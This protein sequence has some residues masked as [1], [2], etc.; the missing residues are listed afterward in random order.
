MKV[1]PTPFFPQCAEFS[2]FIHF[3]QLGCIYVSKYLHFPFPPTKPSMKML[4]SDF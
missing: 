4:N 3:K 2:M 1:N